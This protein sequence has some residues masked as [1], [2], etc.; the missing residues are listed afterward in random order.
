VLLHTV[1][2]DDEDKGED[3]GEQQGDSNRDSHNIALVFRQFARLYESALDPEKPAQ[4]I[5][6]AKMKQTMT[7]F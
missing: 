5:I 3:K 4:L 2:R 1:Q 6:H 7:F